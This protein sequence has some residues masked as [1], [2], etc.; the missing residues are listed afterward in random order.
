MI[1]DAF[2]FSGELDILEC[3][4]DELGDQDCMFVFAEAPV[5]FQGTPKPLVFEEHRERFARWKDK[6]TYVVADLSPFEGNLNP[7]ARENE[8]R[9]QLLS[10][11]LAYAE[12][13]DLVIFGDA[14]EIPRKG[15]ISVLRPETV[16]QLRHH[17]FAVDWQHPEKWNGP[18]IIRA[19]DAGMLPGSHF[20]AKRMEWEPVPD[21]GWHFSWLGGPDSIREKVLSFSHMEL[22]PGVLRFLDEG[23]LCQ[24]GMMWANSVG[25]G[26]L[27][28]LAT[29][30]DDGYPDWIREGRCPDSWYRPRQEA[31][32]IFP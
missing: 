18:V 21:A 2:L 32:N 27:Q 23:H 16:L 8:Q 3:R 15:I 17:M 20:R 19:G 1:W 9:D 5:T 30:L 22:I 24:D 7:W 6:I 31:C 29:Q 26:E 13:D 25:E 10:V 11:V 28:L 4:L 12:P 14:D